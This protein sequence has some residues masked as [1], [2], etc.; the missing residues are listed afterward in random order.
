MLPATR[1]WARRRRRARIMAH[2]ATIFTF[3]IVAAL[4][5]CS[6]NANG[7]ADNGGGSSGSTASV[8]GSVAGA[9][10]SAST[11]SYGGVSVGSDASGL[12]VAAYRLH[13]KGER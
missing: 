2:V 1:E 13:P 4:A 11:Q 12:H 9:S 3:T 6:A 10:G 8:T 7:G 5:G